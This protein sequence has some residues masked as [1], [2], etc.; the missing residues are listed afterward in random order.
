MA[1]GWVRELKG[2]AFEPVSAGIEKHGLDPKAVQV[3]RE[4]GVDIS[5]Q[6]SK[7]ISELE[8]QEFDLVITICNNAESKCPAFPGKAKRIHHP[9]DNPPILSRKSREDSLN[10]YRRVRDEI[11]KFVSDLSD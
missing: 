8:D 9:F 2:N 1:E 4:A 10:I 5:H 3:M 7:L 11:K 6:H